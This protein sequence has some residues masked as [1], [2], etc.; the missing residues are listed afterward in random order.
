MG[1]RGSS[2]GN[3]PRTFSLDPLKMA[4]VKMPDSIKEKGIDSK[5]YKEWI[6]KNWR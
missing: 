3:I 1:G 4:R 6:Y 2:S 5:E